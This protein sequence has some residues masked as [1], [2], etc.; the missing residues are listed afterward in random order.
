LLVLLIIFMVIQPHWEQK[1][2]VRTPQE[3]PAGAEPSPEMLMLTVTEDWRFALNSK[4][5]EMEDL[6][7]VLS[8]LMDQRSADSRTL[9]IKGPQ[10][11]RYSSVVSLIDLAK[12]AGAITIGLVAD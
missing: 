6:V 1:L 2:S 5:L 10:S 8:R 7:A 12:G 11:L 3:P 4:P 9:L